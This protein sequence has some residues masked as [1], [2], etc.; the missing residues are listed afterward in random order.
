M[1]SAY[2]SVYIQIETVNFAFAKHAII[3]CFYL[4]SSVQEI[5]MPNA[6]Y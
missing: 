4:C 3:V 5:A 2:N 6:K 1:K